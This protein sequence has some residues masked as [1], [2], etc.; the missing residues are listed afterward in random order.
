MLALGAAVLLAASAAEA[1]PQ[2]LA[3]VDRGQLLRDKQMLRA[4]RR[5]FITCSSETC[6]A[7]VRSD[8]IKWLADVD[9]RLP[10]FVVRAVD[11]EG[12]DVEDVRVLVDGTAEVERLSGSTLAIDPGPRTVRFEHAGLVAVERRIVAREGEHNRILDVVFLRA[13]SSTTPARR[14]TFPVAGVVFSGLAA[15][16]VGAFTFLAATGKSDRDEL[17]S[18][19]APR[20]S[21]SSVDAARTKIVI[22]NVALGAAIVS[23]GFAGYFFLTPTA[24]GGGA[25]GMAGRF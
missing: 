15:L 25:V 11:E 5:E 21:T 22:A 20:C 12:H 16:G 3:A 1:T 8:C 9:Q 18:T 4:A 14:S 2:C 7:I 13:P 6:A 10:T 24:D 23:A 19:C 17:R